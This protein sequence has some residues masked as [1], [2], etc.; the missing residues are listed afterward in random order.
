MPRR[1]EGAGKEEWHKHK[2]KSMVLFGLLIFL[3][4][5]MSFYQVSWPVIL[6]V[7][8]ILIILKGLYAK[9]K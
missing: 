1:N 3:V 5:V 8:G 4:G 9:M 7:A 6:M 2:G